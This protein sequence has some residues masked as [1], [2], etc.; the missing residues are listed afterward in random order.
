MT[1]GAKASS[2]LGKNKISNMCMVTGS[3][4]EQASDYVSDSRAHF[5]AW[6]DKVE[7]ANFEEKI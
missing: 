4:D 1:L 2:S 5:T 3:V 6:H 7:A